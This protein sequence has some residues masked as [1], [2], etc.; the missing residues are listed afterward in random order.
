[1]FS[2]GWTPEARVSRGAKL[3]DKKV[4][5]WDG[6]TYTVRLDLN[7][8]TDCVLG[9]LFSVRGVPYDFRTGYLR[10]LEELFGSSFARRRASWYGFNPAGLEQTWSYEEKWKDEIVKRRTAR[11]I[12]ADCTN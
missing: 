6:R 5:G 9:Q 4:P 12:E 8:A 2:F 3:L 11:L 1:M 7:S 10:G